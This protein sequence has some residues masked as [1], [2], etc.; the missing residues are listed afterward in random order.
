META[1]I[2][3][4][5]GTVIGSMKSLLTNNPYLPREV[6]SGREVG[7]VQWDKVDVYS[8]AKIMMYCLD[9]NLVQEEIDEDDIYDNFSDDVADILVD[10]FESSVNLIDDAESFKEKLQDALAEFE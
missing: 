7:N 5:D 9:P 3:G 2:Q 1:K 6:R 8:V 4:Y 10:I